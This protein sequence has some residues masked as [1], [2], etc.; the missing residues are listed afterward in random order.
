[1][2]LRLQDD[3]LE[4][5]GNF[6]NNRSRL[7]RLYGIVAREKVLAYY[8]VDFPPR[9]RDRDPKFM[10][11]VI[12]QSKTEITDTIPDARFIVVIYPNQKTNPFI[13]SKLIP[14]LE[15]SFIEYLDYTD[16]FDDK[17]DYWI[18]HDGHPNAKVHEE[19]GTRLVHDLALSSP[20]D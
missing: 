9:V 6:V 15:E 5:R 3:T 17:P 11:R 1:M 13:G 18:K 14:Y 12:E 10:A 19:L 16:L 7:N 20:T 2:L 8:K 4:H